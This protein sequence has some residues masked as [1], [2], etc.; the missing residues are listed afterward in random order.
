MSFL[1]YL[2]GQFLFNC[3]ICAFLQHLRSDVE[4]FSRCRERAVFVALRRQC[5]DAVW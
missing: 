3:C 2:Y 4:V 5:L 1:G